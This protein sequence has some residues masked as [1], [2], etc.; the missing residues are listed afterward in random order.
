M[1]EKAARGNER[2]RH[3]MEEDYIEYHEMRWDE[4]GYDIM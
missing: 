3:G 4:L 2:C 1:R